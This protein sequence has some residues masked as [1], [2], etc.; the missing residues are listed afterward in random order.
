MSTDWSVIVAIGAVLISAIALI[1]RSF[2][3]S[4]SIREHEEFRGKVNDQFKQLRDDINRQLDQLHD[5]ARHEHDLLL[6]RIKVLEQTRPT[7]SEIMAHLDR[8]TLRK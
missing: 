2:D 5:D 8:R 7:T 3:K 4:L 1:A 6:D